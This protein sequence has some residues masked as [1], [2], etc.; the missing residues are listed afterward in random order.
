[1]KKSNGDNYVHPNFNVEAPKLLKKTI[2]ELNK[3]GID[4][5]NLPFLSIN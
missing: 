3:Q 5:R 4:L 1:M 2:E